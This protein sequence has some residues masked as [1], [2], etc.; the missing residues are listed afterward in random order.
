M[1]EMKE[2]KRIIGRPVQGIDE[3]TF[4]IIFIIFISLIIFI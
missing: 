4:D 3:P 2:M 1:K